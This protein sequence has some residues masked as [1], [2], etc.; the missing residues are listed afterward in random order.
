MYASTGL[1]K[2]YANVD[3]LAEDSGISADVLRETLAKYTKVALSGERDEFGK[4]VYP[5]SKWDSDQTIYSALITPVIHYTMG[6][7][8]INTKAQIL[9]QSG[10][11]LHGLFGAG[12][13]TGGVHGM[14]RLA[15]NSLLECVVYGRISAK[16]A[17]DYCLQMEKQ[18]KIKHEL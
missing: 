13:V 3:E 4:T 15:G 17:I 10:E 8:Q 14:N 18:K 1:V 6:G 12:E 5:V 16:S 7:L 2:K 11:P 9:D